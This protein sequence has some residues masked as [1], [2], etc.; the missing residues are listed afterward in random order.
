VKVATLSPAAPAAGAPADLRSW[1][2]IQ[3]DDGGATL[4]I[5]DGIVRAT[6]TGLDLAVNQAKDTAGAAT[7]ALFNWS[8]LPASGLTIDAG[9]PFAISGRL[10]TLNVADVLTGQAN[11]AVR[12][13]IVDV[14]SLALT[15]ATLLTIEITD[16]EVGAGIDGALSLDVAAES[17]RVATLAPAR[18]AAGATVTDTRQWTGVQLVNGSATL[19]IGGGL[20]TGA[21]SGLSVEVNNAK[22]AAGTTQATPLDWAL[23][24]AS[25]P[26]GFELGQLDPSTGFGVAGQLDSL[27]IAG[28]VSG[29][30]AFAISRRTVAVNL[31]TDNATAELIGA[32][33]FTVG[34]S[35]LQLR[36]GTADAG[37]AITDGVVAIATLSVPRATAPTTD[38]RSWTTIQASRLAGTLNVADLVTATLT[39]VRLDINRFAGQRVAGTTTTP[40]TV[41]NWTTAFDSTATGRSARRRPTRCSSRRSAPRRSA[42][43]PAHRCRRPRPSAR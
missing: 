27:D 13:A 36:I 34:L 32:T 12:R 16:L 23:V 5:G 24:A 10:A 29:S 4:S 1:V 20:V 41:L 40:A 42:P 33:L 21:V 18:P 30:A 9:A 2:G 3:I 11:F 17:L 39:D 38:T 22:G 37:F 14:P 26:A 6:V 31:D 8:S 7:N 28:I 35:D 15:G 43:C 25:F 19:S